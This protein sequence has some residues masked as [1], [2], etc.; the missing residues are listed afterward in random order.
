[1]KNDE[2]IFGEGKQTYRMAVSHFPD[3]QGLDEKGN[4]LAL[5][6]FSRSSFH[7]PS[8]PPFL[9][10]FISFLQFANVNCGLK[11]TWE[12]GMVMHT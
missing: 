1:M 7:P 3:P 6:F 2:G 11:K 9:C 10:L 5:L 8:H 12:S 4:E